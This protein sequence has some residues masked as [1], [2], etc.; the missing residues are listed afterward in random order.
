MGTKDLADG[1]SM[2]MREQLPL[3]CRHHFVFGTI[4]QDAEATASRLVGDILVRPLR[5]LGQRRRCLHL[6]GPTRVAPRW[7]VAPSPAKPPSCGKN[8]DRLHCR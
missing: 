7:A 6:P 4:V 5:R 3:G 2:A 8:P 1:M